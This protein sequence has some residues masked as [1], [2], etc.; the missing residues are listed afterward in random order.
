MNKFIGLGNVTREPEARS[1]ADGK[2]VVNVSIAINEKYKNKN[3]EYTET[4][5]YVNCVFFGGLADV[6][7]KYVTKG[8]LILVEG[9]MKTEKYTD[10]N[11]VEKYSTKIIGSEMRMCGG[12]RKST[13]DYKKVQTVDEAFPKTLADLNSD[14][15][16]EV[17]F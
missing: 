7:A 13:V 5:E 3:G 14:D 8:Q 9:K 6:V 12:E 17:P 10:K 2:T 4:T 16:F 1:M 15:P 11:G